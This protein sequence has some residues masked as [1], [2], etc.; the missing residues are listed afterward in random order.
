LGKTYQELAVDDF[1]DEHRE[2]GLNVVPGDALLGGR[3]ADGALTLLV[4]R[5]HTLQHADLYGG[6]K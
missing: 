2:S 5:D 4:Q 3:V 6:G 1:L